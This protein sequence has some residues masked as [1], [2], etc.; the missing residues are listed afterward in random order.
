MAA[1]ILSHIE[2]NLRKEYSYNSTA[3]W[4]NM[5]CYSLNITFK[6]KKR[7]TQLVVVHP[8]EDGYG[9]NRCAACSYFRQDG[10]SVVTVSFVLRSS[11]Y[12]ES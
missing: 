7:Q 6:N 4:A 2:P 12:S 8:V 1:T 9:G 5:T 11:Y 10:T 3:F